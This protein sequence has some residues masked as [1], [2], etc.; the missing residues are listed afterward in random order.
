MVTPRDVARKGDKVLAW[1]DPTYVAAR[2]Y[3]S[4]GLRPIDHV[5]SG[6]WW[7]GLALDVI[8]LKPLSVAACLW[9]FFGD[10]AG[11]EGDALDRCLVRM[12]NTATW[13]PRA[14]EEVTGNGTH[15]LYATP[16]SEAP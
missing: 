16:P 3:A 12:V 2:D 13:L 14:I 10:R 1:D 5:S 4:T 6:A 7:I 11:E 9:G 15:R 8:L